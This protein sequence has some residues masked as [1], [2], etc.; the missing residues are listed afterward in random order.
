MKNI[1]TKV[2]IGVLFFINFAVAQFGVDIKVS[3]TTGGFWGCVEPWII[4]HQGIFY[5]VWVSDYTASFDMHIYF[6]KST[7]MGNTWTPSVRVDDASYPEY[8]LYPS[9]AVNPSGTLYCIWYKGGSSPDEILFSKSTDG[10]NTWSPSTRVDDAS[11]QF[12]GQNEI[13]AIGD[14]LFVVWE[15]SEPGGGWKC[16]FSK[17]TDG[18]ITW[19]SKVQISPDTL[20]TSPRIEILGDTIYV[21]YMTYYEYYD[22]YLSRS[23]DGG[24]TWEIMGRINDVSS[25]EQRY[26]D[27][28][29]TPEGVL[30]CAWYD[31]R[32]GNCE[33]RFSKSFDGGVSWTPS[34]RISDTTW[35][36]DPMKGEIRMN[37]ACVNENLIYAVWQDDRNGQW[38][39]FFTKSEDGGIT[40]SEDIIIND[41]AYIDSVQWVPSLCLDGVG[42][43]CVVWSDGRSGLGKMHIYFDRGEFT[44]IEEHQ[45]KPKNLSFTVYPTIL[46]E[47]M[48]VKFQIDNVKETQE[49]FSL[50]IYDITGRI[51]KSF[52][53]LPNTQ[54]RITIFWHG[55]DNSGKRV[56]KGV[57]FCTLSIG[58]YKITKRILFLK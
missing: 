20:S 1:I 48:S 39:I 32:S 51:V 3:D 4:Y 38:D 40:W 53:F 44:K 54:G 11:G 41:S 57:Y 16:Y 2:V 15:A 23:I 35:P 10:G 42:N 52:T 36:Q 50:Q 24:S 5:V 49:K 56:K 31:W 21:A 29:L 9:L 8:C 27:I 28:A 30:C 19:S 6:S 22:I 43:P 25:D 58:N 46:R 18:G 33:I 7:D 47:G 26:H 12:C 45:G 17:S 14:T 13:K 37:L 34:I 55:R